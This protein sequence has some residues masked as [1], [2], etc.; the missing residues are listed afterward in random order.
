MYDTE[1]V[2]WDNI[3]PLFQ[4]LAIKLYAY[5]SMLSRLGGFGIGRIWHSWKLWKLSLLNLVCRGFIGTRFG[6]MNGIAAKLEPGIDK[7]SSI[8]LSK[9]ELWLLTCF[10][11]MPLCQWEDFHFFNSVLWEIFIISIIIRASFEFW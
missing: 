5:Q 10:F 7:S 9:L 1:A 6:K 3:Q 8:V 2:S 11:H 4:V